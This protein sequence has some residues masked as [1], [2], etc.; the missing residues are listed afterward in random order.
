MKA[1]TDTLVALLLVGSAMAAPL[2][3]HVAGGERTNSIVPRAN[4]RRGEGDASTDGTRV[5]GVGTDGIRVNRRLP[6]DGTDGNDWT[7]VTGVGTDGTRVTR[8]EPQ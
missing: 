3:P 7:R 2:S 8:G 5:T 1:A 6:G 4:A